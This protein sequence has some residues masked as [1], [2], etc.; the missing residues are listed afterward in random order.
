MTSTPRRSP[1][2]KRKL[3]D[4]EKLVIFMRSFHAMSQKSYWPQ[5]R[6]Q[7][8]VDLAGKTVIEVNHDTGR[9][10][11]KESPLDPLAT[12]LAGAYMRKLIT[13]TE[14]VTFGNLLKILEREFGRD[15]H[16]NEAR[17]VWRQA[18]D[19]QFNFLADG[20]RITSMKI[21]FPRSWTE[22]R[23]RD[24]G[25]RREV[26]LSIADFAK[27]YFYTG[28]LHDYDEEADTPKRRLARSV[29]P[30]LR[31]FLAQL[32][33]AA[34]LYISIIAHHIVSTNIPDLCP[35]NCQ[36]AT[37]MTRNIANVTAAAGSD[38]SRISDEG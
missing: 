34:S 37:I 3:T 12:D 18:E 6:A 9:V 26:K 36:E 32:A 16:L 31:E 8:R 33:I 22:G 21:D 24:E 5:L 15:A 38:T 2:P 4:S 7:A 19:P 20:D 1:T 27:P 10:R 28:F 13:G 23:P 14:M 35:E 25:E 17:H 11:M 29:P 30:V